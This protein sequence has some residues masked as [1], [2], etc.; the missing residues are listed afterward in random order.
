MQNTSLTH[1]RSLSLSLFLN[2]AALP[3]PETTRQL[4]AGEG[5]SAQYPQGKE[6][7]RPAIFRA[8]TV[9]TPNLGSER[10]GAPVYTRLSFFFF[11]RE[12]SCVFMVRGEW[13]CGVAEDTLWAPLSQGA[14]SKEDPSASSTATLWPGAVPHLVEALGTPNRARSY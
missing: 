10:V 4:F 5:F 9:C 11:F 7:F 1:S 12:C 8:G 3:H 13:R 2:L 14:L 6:R